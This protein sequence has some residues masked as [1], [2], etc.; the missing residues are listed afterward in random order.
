MGLGIGHVGYSLEMWDHLINLKLRIIFK[1][2][3]IFSRI[4]RFLWHLYCEQVY[5]ILSKYFYWIVNIRIGTV[6]KTLF[7]SYMALAV[8]Q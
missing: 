1:T 6:K 4:W 5:N 8:L 7:H 3:E 2:R